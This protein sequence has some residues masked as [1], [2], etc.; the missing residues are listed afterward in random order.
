MLYHYDIPNDA[1]RLTDQERT[2]HEFIEQQLSLEE[3][4]SIALACERIEDIVWAQYYFARAKQEKSPEMLSLLDEITEDT[5]KI[6]RVRLG[7]P[8]FVFYS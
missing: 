5:L 1:S 6:T 4:E 7:K 8:E 2:E 3:I